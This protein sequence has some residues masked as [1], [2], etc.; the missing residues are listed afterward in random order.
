[1]YYSLPIAYLL[2]FVSGFGVL[3]LHRIYLGKIGTGILYMCT[4]GLGAVGAVYDFF[5]LPYQVEEA[6]RRRQIEDIL[7][8]SMGSAGGPRPAD[9]KRERLE[10]TI[11]RL[12]R[13]GN[14]VTS[15]AEV[16]LEADIPIEKARAAL[17]ALVEKGFAELRV[18]K[19]GVI[20][21]V[22][23]EFVKDPSRLDIEEV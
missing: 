4:F 7:S 12:A 17:D 13:A 10:R 6:N 21:Y 14:G 18:K 11:L 9:R 2:W 3:G 19:T 8:H 22:F 1:M 23:P 20:V 16:A 15:P 5:T